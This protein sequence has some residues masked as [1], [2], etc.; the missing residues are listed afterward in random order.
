MDEYHINNEA[1]FTANRHRC[2]TWIVVLSWVVLIGIVV[3]LAVE[4]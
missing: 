1:L 4:I 3:L 2:P